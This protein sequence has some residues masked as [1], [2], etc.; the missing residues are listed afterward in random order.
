MAYMCIEIPILVD[1]QLVN[2]GIYVN[3][4]IGVM[5]DGVLCA[6]LSASDTSA[7]YT[8]LY[9]HY[10]KHRA[11]V[12]VDSVLKATREFEKTIKSLRNTK[13]EETS[14]EQ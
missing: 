5:R 4:T 1:Y 14:S 10:K 8:K 6:D 3:G 11:D 7:F 9:R 13:Q 12:I 2:V